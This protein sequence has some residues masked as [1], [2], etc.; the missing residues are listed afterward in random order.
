MGSHYIPQKY[1]KGFTNSTCPNALWQFDKKTYTFS[2]KRL[3]I[4]KI[5]Q[6]RTF[7]DAETEASLNEVVE[8]PGNCVLEKLRS[9]NIS[10]T[11]EE[12]VHLSIY[13]ATMIKR[14]P[15]HRAKG[16]AMVPE[17][18]KEITSDLRNKIRELQSADKISALQANKYLTDTDIVE[19]KY[20]LQ[21]PSNVR[22]QI[23]SPW[24]SENIIKAIYEMHWRFVQAQ[25]DECFL[26]SDNPAFFFD[27]YGLRTDKS[28]LTFPVSRKLAIFG[29]WTP[30][31]NGNNVIDQ[32]F[33]VREANRRL[34]D[35]TSRF[36][37]ASN[38][39]DWIN[40][41]AKKSKP[42]LSRIEW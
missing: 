9:G 24:P 21:T 22:K 40:K 5:A 27:C 35:K 16:E 14:V 29:S 11:V 42:F 39:A 3:S 26:T 13:I 1:L 25:D 19:A 8:R 10:L 20:E 30:V 7:Y 31:S 23:R 18:L 17:V 37:Y 33:L 32:K 34:I 36:I 15:Y 12:K 38:R 6:Q 4:V 41:I 2:N 28:E